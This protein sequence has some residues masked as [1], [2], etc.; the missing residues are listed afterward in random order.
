MMKAAPVSITGHPAKINVKC[1]KTQCF[2][3][4]SL[5]GIGGDAAL[6]VPPEAPSRNV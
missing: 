2:R 3:H 1:P 4:F 5:R 6:N